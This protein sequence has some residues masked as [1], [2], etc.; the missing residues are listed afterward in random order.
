[1]TMTFWLPL[2]L[3]TILA[4]IFVIYPMVF[5]QPRKDRID[6]R[7]QNLETYRSRMQEM[8]A[9]YENGNVD[10]ETYEKLK[11]ELEASLLD[12][13]GDPATVDEESISRGGRR[14]LVV[15][16]LAAVVFVPAVSYLFYDLYG[17]HDDVA[18]FQ[19]IQ[20][21]RSEAED[22]QQMLA[23]VDN[24]RQR[25]EEEPDHVEGWAVLA[26]TNMQ[27]QRYA[28]A[29]S[30][31]RSLAE[32]AERTGEGD[33][34]QAWGMAAQADFLQSQGQV[35]PSVREAI[36]QA[37]S[38]NPDEVNALGLLGIDAFQQG[39]YREALEHWERIVA[40]APDHPQL[41]SIRQGI[42]AA[43][44][45]LGEPVPAEALES[46]EAELTDDTE[47]DVEGTR[48]ETEVKLSEEA[49]ADVSGE[50]TVFVYARAV[51][52]PPRPLAISRMQVD[53]LP[54]SVTLDTSMGM[55]E[56]GELEAGASVMLVARVSRDGNAT[57]QPGDWEGETGP[58]VVG[59]Q[60]ETAEI[61][62]GEPVR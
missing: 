41:P 8:D 44:S 5:F 55:T 11:L 20:E 24:L 54:A 14:T 7:Q 51:D 48:V 12:D 38:L 28:Q 6:Q 57:P 35:T 31:F 36:E 58:V 46:G 61:L 18:Q 59:A 33:E 3:L 25:L 19:E 13:V 45:E 27:L 22:P 21:M 60:E 16:T 32:A 30:A 53:D 4:L 42:A 9:E 50:H 47:V 34:G 43:Y 52:G 1:M 26:Q 49:E 2:V 39:E 29:A 15:V 23:L 56:D 10:Q 17:F 37:L 40:V 62:I